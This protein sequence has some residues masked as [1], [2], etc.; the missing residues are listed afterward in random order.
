[1][2]KFFL[3]GLLLTACVSTTTEMFARTAVAAA[4]GVP[5]K[6]S[7]AYAALEA[8]LA[9]DGKI[10]SNPVWSQSK[11]VY[12]VCFVIV[13]IAAADA[14]YTTAGVSFKGNGQRVY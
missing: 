13:D 1:M 10:L 6:V 14:T 5:A 2:K 3:A 8:E 12:S 7:A 4:P 11:G 9:A